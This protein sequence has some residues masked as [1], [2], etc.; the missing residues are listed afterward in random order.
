MSGGA[1]VGDRQRLLL[2]LELHAEEPGLA[3]Q[4]V[5]ALQIGGKLGGA[6]FELRLAFLRAFGLQLE[7][8]LL[9]LDA[10]EHRG[11]GCLLITQRL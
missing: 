2:L 4:L 1:L 5:L 3:D 8:F 7:C 10:G 6:A 9:H 11:P